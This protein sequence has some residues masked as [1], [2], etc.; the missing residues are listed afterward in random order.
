MI[1]IRSLPSPALPE[2][3]KHRDEILL[4]I[5]E[6][7]LLQM[8]ADARQILFLMDVFYKELFEKQG[9]D[10]GVFHGMGGSLAKPRELGLKFDSDYGPGFAAFLA[11]AVFIY[12]F[13]HRNRQ[14]TENGKE[15]PPS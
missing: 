14:P 3:L 12:C 1:R 9:F 7:W 4:A 11:E 10:L 6:L 8:P 15:Q 13:T 2:F 5:K